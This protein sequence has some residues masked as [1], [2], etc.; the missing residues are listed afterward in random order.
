MIIRHDAGFS[1]S[2]RR[3]RGTRIIAPVRS[4][5]H[6]QRSYVENRGATVEDKLEVVLDHPRA[7]PPLRCPGRLPGGRDRGRVRCPA[8]APGATTPRPPP[9]GDPH[10]RRPLSRHRPHGA[11]A[12]RSTAGGPRPRRGCPR[13]VPDH[14]PVRIEP[15][16]RHADGRALRLVLRG[17]P[18]RSGARP[19]LAGEFPLLQRPPERPATAGGPTRGRTSSRVASGGWRPQARRRSTPSGSRADGGPPPWGW[20]PQEPVRRR[21]RSHRATTERL[22]RYRWAICRSEPSP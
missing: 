16:D 2:S 11:V 7:G 21:R 14:P 19:L 12:P 22:T 8:N 5:A 9:G 15:G 3:R 10:H 6:H 4:P 17:V 13:L 18:L 1:R 20:G